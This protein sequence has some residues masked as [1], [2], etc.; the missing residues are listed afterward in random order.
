M[1]QRGF[2]APV[3]RFVGSVKAMKKLL[4]PS[5]WYFTNKH[6]SMLEQC[7][8][9]LLLLL[10]SSPS[11]HICSDNIHTVGWRRGPVCNL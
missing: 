11:E 2:P 6:L 7:W 1:S 5:R 10:S 4:F 3:F 8:P 9:I